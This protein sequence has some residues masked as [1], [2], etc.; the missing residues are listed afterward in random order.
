M[1]S[2]EC[3]LCF[4]QWIILWFFNCEDRKCRSF[5]ILESRKQHSVEQSENEITMSIP[6]VDVVMNRLLCS[7][8]SLLTFSNGFSSPLAC[9]QSCESC[10]PS[11]PRCLTCA[12]K[13]VLHDGKCISECPGGYYADATGRCRGKTWASSSWSSLTRLGAVSVHLG[14]CVSYGK[15]SKGIAF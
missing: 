8:G 15:M 14:I 12:K 2:S 5:E 9:D 10:G 4:V 3:L 1:E 7:V 6:T 13:A 11:G